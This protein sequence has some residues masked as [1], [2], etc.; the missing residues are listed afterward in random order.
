MRWQLQE[1]VFFYL[2]IFVITTL[3]ASRVFF[4]P[5]TNI[6]KAPTQHVKS[7]SMY[8]STVCGRMLNEGEVVS[9]DKIKTASNPCPICIKAK[10]KKS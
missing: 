7:I 6:M 3:P 4:Y 10:Q 8:Q 1:D 2:L 9:I 5:K